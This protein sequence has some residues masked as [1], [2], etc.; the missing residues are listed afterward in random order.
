MFDPRDVLLPVHLILRAFTH[1]LLILRLT[2]KF[3]TNKIVRTTHHSAVSY[4]VDYTGVVATILDEE[5]ERERMLV[6]T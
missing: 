5:N 4:C 3:T 6:L 1:L 2:F